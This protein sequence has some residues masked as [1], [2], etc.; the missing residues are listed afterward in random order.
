VSQGSPEL[1]DELS[2]SG[3][4]V[5]CEAR[6]SGVSGL[7]RLEFV[8]VEHDGVRETI[9]CDLLVASPEIVAE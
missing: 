1:L 5:Q 3:I 9:E 7:S 8:T 6:V 2:R 4:V